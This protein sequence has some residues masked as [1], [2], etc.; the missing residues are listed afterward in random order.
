MFKP[1]DKAVIDTVQ[2]ADLLGSDKNLNFFATGCNLF[3][4]QVVI[5][6]K[7]NG[8]AALKSKIN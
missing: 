4:N 6:F 3:K 8:A 2:N 5:A 1:H 7:Y